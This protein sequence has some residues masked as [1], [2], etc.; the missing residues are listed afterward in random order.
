MFKRTTSPAGLWLVPALLLGGFMIGR[1]QDSSAQLTPELKQQVLDAVGGVLQKQAYLPGVDFSKWPDFLAT[2]KQAIDKATTPRDFTKAVNEAFHRFGVSHIVMTTPQQAQA[3]RDKS[4]IGIGVSLQLE[5]EGLRVVNLFPSAPAAQAG[6][7]L[8]DLIIEADGKKPENPAQLVGDEGTSITIKVKKADGQ[9]KTYTL[10]RTKFSSV[11]P[12]TLTWIGKD[13][14]VLRIYTFDRSYDSKH[15]E[16]LIT[17]A[18]KAKELIVDLRSNG[19]GVVLNMMHLLGL[20]LKDGTPVGSFVSRS[21]V[22]R[23]VKETGGKPDDSLKIAFWS[24]RKVRAQK[25]SV[26]AYTG[27]VAVLINGGTGSAAEIVTAALQEILEAPVVGSRSAGAVLVSTVESLPGGYQMQYPV[28]DYVTMHGTR[29][30]GKGIEPD[31]EA[32]LA[33]FGQKDEAIDKAIALLHRMEL[34]DARY[35]KDESGN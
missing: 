21:M 29:L 22:E 13:T 23:F 24:P 6:V 31:A 11:R 9:I 26:G 3:R 28:S 1:A 12:E 5:A 25:Q 35:G 2:E 7:E 14:A 18:A 8:G 15:I 33:R 20:L 19:G 34:R 16:D 10:T 30:E 17:Q 4:A 32:P 27:H